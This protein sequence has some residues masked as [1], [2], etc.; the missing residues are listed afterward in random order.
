MTDTIW[1]GITQSKTLDPKFAQT[2]HELADA[3]KI[4]DWTR[5]IEILSEHPQLANSSRPDGKSLFTPLHQAAYG[6]ASA[7]IVKQIVEF[8]T[9]RTLQNAKGEKPID[10]AKKRQHRHLISVLTPE[11]K[12]HTLAG[13]LPKI[14]QHFHHIIRGRANHLVEEHALRLPELEPLLELEQPKMWFAVPGMYGG[15]NYWLETEGGESRL[16]TESWCRV[17]SGSGKRHEINAF[18]SRLV[19]KG[20]V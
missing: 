2:R 6:G 4:F 20:F 14:Q 12:H 16:I 13:A 3:A 19:D 8:G 11:Y 17:V 7:E 15:F 18:G 10:I 9:W 1:D 5:T